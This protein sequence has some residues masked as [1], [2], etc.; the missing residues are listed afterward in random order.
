[1]AVQT[2]CS[3]GG[4]TFTVNARTQ[5]SPQPVSSMFTPTLQGGFR[6][7]FGVFVQDQVITLKWPVLNATQYAA[8]Y[9]VY[10]QATNQT[11]VDWTGTSKTVFIEDFTYDS[12]LPAGVD[13]YQNVAMQLRVVSIP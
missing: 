7:V 8:L 6:T 4:V 11:F 10:T 13:A 1:M 5:L 2:T 3:L 9:A 12:V